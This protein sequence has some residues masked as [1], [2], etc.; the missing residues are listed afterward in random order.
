MLIATKYY[1]LT[2]IYFRDNKE[3]DLRPGAY[4]VHLNEPPITGLHVFAWSQ[5]SYIIAETAA[6]QII[7]FPGTAFVEGAIYYIKLNRIIEVGPHLESTQVMGIS[8]S[9]RP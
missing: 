9:E 3:V 2:D 6:G 1:P 7:K 8:T 5:H 4:I